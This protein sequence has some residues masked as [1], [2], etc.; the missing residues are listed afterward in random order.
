MLPWRPATILCSIADALIGKPRG[1]QRGLGRAGPFGSGQEPTVRLAVCGCQPG[2]GRAMALRAPLFIAVSVRPGLRHLVLCL[3]P[4]GHGTQL[5]QH[6]PSSHRL[7]MCPHKPQRTARGDG[8]EYCD[9][10]A[11]RQAGGGH[12]GGSLRTLHQCLTTR[13]C[14]C[15]GCDAGWRLSLKMFNE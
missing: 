11:R 7:P 10:Y 12:V 4:K 9:N 3:H 6:P 5:R 8:Q 15:N 13:P 1:P 2:P 14:T